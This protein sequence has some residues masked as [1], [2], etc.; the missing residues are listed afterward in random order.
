MTEFEA[1]LADDPKSSDAHMNLGALYFQRPNGL[2]EAVRHFETAIQIRPDLSEGHYY[3]GMALAELPGRRADAV[4]H[5]DTALRI[6]PDF[7]EVREALR[8]MRDN[9]SR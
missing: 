8:Q 4:A 7:P 5:F 9:K 2:A 6:R 3:I 1:A